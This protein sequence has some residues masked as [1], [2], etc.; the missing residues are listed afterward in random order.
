LLRQHFFFSSWR[1][2]EGLAR[3]QAGTRTRDDRRAEARNQSGVVFAQRSQISAASV[4]A[5]ETLY[6]RSPS[7]SI[8]HQR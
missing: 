7:P 6:E 2:P 1:P 3:A 4:G 5:I 8:D